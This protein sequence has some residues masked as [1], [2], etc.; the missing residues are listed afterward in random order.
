[1]KYL[2]CLLVLLVCVPVVLG[3]LAP[4]SFAQD[5]IKTEAEKSEISWSRTDVSV[6]ADIGLVYNYND[7]TKDWSVYSGHLPISD[8][9]QPSWVSVS[10][11]Y[12]TVK[13]AL[14][15]LEKEHAYD[16]V[17]EAYGMLFGV[18]AGKFYSSFPNLEYGLNG[19]GGEFAPTLWGI[20]PSV[21]YITNHDGPEG[22]YASLKV[23]KYADIGYFNGNNLPGLGDTQG[24]AWAGRV[25]V[26]A[27]EGSVLAGYTWLHGRG[28]TW[29][30]AYVTPNMFGRWTHRLDG[31]EA[32]SFGPIL[33]FAHGRA[34]LVAAPTFVD[35][36]YDE[37][38]LQFS[39][40]Y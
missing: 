19:T 32:I 12:W 21:G 20:R 16:T 1:M 14:D 10:S 39:L 31:V 24:E 28:E 27:W 8:F 38:A 37:L 22:W 4:S 25:S 23:L 2:V 34:S 36:H 26:P 15:P 17:Q 5:N 6:H 29:T 40:K 13:L 18:K 3:A 33:S 30:A 9:G 11:K 35:R 7:A